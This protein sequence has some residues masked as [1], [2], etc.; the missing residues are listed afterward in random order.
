M[1]DLVALFAH[2]RT[3]L[4]LMLIILPMIDLGFMVNANKSVADL[5]Q[6]FVRDVHFVAAGVK[7]FSYAWALILHIV[8]MRRGLVT[9]GVL[10]CFWTLA[11]IFG[12]MT[13]RFAPEPDIEDLK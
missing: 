5:G 4:T 1:F 11:M 13:F 2:S 3:I 10:S 6:V 9:S 7:I 8:C 12:I